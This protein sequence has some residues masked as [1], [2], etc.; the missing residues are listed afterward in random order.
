MSALTNRG[1]GLPLYNT[2]NSASSY[3]PSLGRLLKIGGGAVALATA[4]KV[5][6]YSSSQSSDNNKPFMNHPAST[7]RLAEQSVT[8]ADP[9]LPPLTAEE[10]QKMGKLNMT[11]GMD[12]FDIIATG[13]K[14]IEPAVNDI[15]AGSN[16]VYDTPEDPITGAAAKPVNHPANVPLDHQSAIL[17]HR[18]AN[19]PETR[20]AVALTAGDAGQHAVR[21]A[22]Q[23]AANLKGTQALEDILDITTDVLTTGAKA[24]SE[25]VLD[26]ASKYAPAKPTGAANVA[27]ATSVAA[28]VGI[29]LAL[30][31]ITLYLKNQKAGGN[32]IQSVMF[33]AILGSRQGLKGIVSDSGNALQNYFLKKPDRTAQNPNPKNNLEKLN[34]FAN[35]QEGGA[36]IQAVTRNAFVGLLSGAKSVFPQFKPEEMTKETALDFLQ[37]ATKKIVAGAGEGTKAFLPDIEN[38]DA[39]PFEK[40][41]SATKVLS[42]SVAEGVAETAAGNKQLT[43][44]LSQL[45]TFTDLMKKFE[46][47]ARAVVS[48]IANATANAAIYSA[49]K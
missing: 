45:E 29:P 34:E 12:V 2:S 3:L 39:S 17:L 10:Y 5:G 40:L 36:L 21:G 6:N 42:R 14:D 22:A 27:A 38:A 48:G 26:G 11:A 32:T 35:T 18:T 31:L 15:L 9:N 1:N 47:P 44:A 25:G 16:I 7:R 43:G 46:G 19:Y 41:Q 30:L 23:G 13:D 4:F 33:D 28:A 49:K 8:Q 20:A 37:S 24:I